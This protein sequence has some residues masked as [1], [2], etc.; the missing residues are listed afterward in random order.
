MLFV[1]LHIFAQQMLDYSLAQ[2]WMISHCDNFLECSLSQKEK[3][4]N[5][6]VQIVVYTDYLI[7]NISAETKL[8][9][10]GSLKS[11]KLLKK[12]WQI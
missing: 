9:M 3:E 11:F 2:V 6:M 10:I 12:L 5:Y 4:G 8:R 7:I 1:H